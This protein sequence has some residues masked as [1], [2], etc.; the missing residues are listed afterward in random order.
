MNFLLSVL[1]KQHT[2]CFFYDYIKVYYVINY[3]TLVNEQSLIKMHSFNIFIIDLLIYKDQ[4][5]LPFW[6]LC[7]QGNIH[8]LLLAMNVPLP[9]L[10]RNFFLF[11]IIYTEL[12]SSKVILFIVVI[13]ALPALY[14]DELSGTFALYDSIPGYINLCNSIAVSFKF[15][16]K[17]DIPLI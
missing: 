9:F 14:T 10:T 2:F 5:K 1:L 3:Y 4:Q 13:S 6:G 7:Q 16:I 17:T 15:G 11:C 12:I 8:H